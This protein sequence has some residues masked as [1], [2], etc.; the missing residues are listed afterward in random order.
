MVMGLFATIA[1]RS[2]GTTGGKSQEMSDSL[3]QKL[4]ARFEA[5]GEALA[6]GSEAHAACAVVGRDL[7]RDGVD[8]SEALHSLRSTFALVVGREPDFESTR[9]LG[10]AWSDETLGYL[11]EVSCE[12]PLTGMA[13][14]AHLRGRL[15]EIQRGAEARGTAA[16]P[17]HALVVVDV[18][19]LAGATDQLASSLVMAQVAS[20]VRLVF[21]GEETIGE[22]SPTR[23]LVIAE[24]ADL[25]NR[26][27]TLRD[28]LDEVT[29]PDSVVR[30]WIEG[31][32]ATAAA[33]S[34]LLDELA[35]T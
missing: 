34:T 18:P 1:N 2:S 26:V 21:E 25:G 19:L 4:P 35:R 22:A 13:T 8:L 20:Q 3:R 5:V 15:A 31:L 12:N 23:L 7:A 9:S 29:P 32:P 17:A 6:A 14:L 33:T 28:L 11:H 30:L 16:E 27:G 10:I 24:R